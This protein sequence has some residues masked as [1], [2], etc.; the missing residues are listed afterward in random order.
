MK[1]KGKINSKTNKIVQ[2]FTG[3]GLEQ[4]LSGGVGGGELAVKDIIPL[5]RQAAAEGIVMLKNSSNTL[6]LKP[7]DTVSVFGRCAVNYFSVGYGSGG[8]IVKPYLKSLTD[9]L[10]AAGVKVNG[11]LKNIYQKWI[12][13]PDNEIF[14]GFWG[15][16]PMNY[17]EMPLTDDVVRDASEKSNVAV[18]VIGRA[19]G[20]DRENTLTKGSYYLTSAEHKMLK[21]I[22]KYFS[23]TVVIMD[24]GNIV[25][26][27]WSKEYGNKIG[28]ILYAWQGG[29]ESG[30][31]LADVL[32]GNVN[33][34]GKL[35]DTIAVTYNKY[36][37]CE[38]FGNAKFNNYAEDI[39]VGYRYFETFARYDV[40]Y[41]FGYGLSYTTFDIT[42]SCDVNDTKVTVNAQVK[43]TGAYAGKEV[44]QVYLSLPQGTLGNPAKILAAF[45]KTKELS[46]G[47]AEDITLSF[48]LRDLAPY[49]DS[50]KSG[51][52]SAFVLERGLYTIWAGTDVRSCEKIIQFDRDERIV[53]SQLS[54]HLAVKKENVFKRI[55]NNNGKIGYEDV[56]CS[57]TDLKS[58]ILSNLPEETPYTFNEGIKLADVKSGKR[59]M[60]EYIAQLTPKELDDISHGEGEMDSPQGVKGN[61]GCLAGVTKSLRDKGIP[62][63]ITCDGPSGIRMK[64]TAALLPCG[65][66]L[67]S[68]FNTDLVER[69]YELIGDEM[70][71][72]GVN[73]LLAPGMNIH[74]DPLCGR[75]FEYFSE[76]PLLTGEI[77]AAVVKGIQSRGASACPKHFACNN[78]EK[79]RNFNDSRVSERALREIYLRGFQR[80]IEKSNPDVIMTSYNKINGVHSHYN[81]EL[82]T[83]VLRGEWGYR[84]LIITDWWMSKGVS[85]EFPKINNDGYRVR[86]QVD[87]LMPG[88]DGYRASAKVGRTLLDSYQ[89][90][91]GITLGELQR[92]AE[93]VLNLAMKHIK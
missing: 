17:P 18:V 66:A 1:I 44:V 33:P 13:N 93:N 29:M 47:E 34:C 16:W 72:H 46:P 51:T 56:P 86:A 15:H 24:C 89:L 26:M 80:M 81:Y 59:T 25:D 63:V 6:P 76:D 53:V 90:P 52:K 45:A 54:Q 57:T 92:T 20:E 91:E 30:S 71:H 87:V 58:E 55:S 61:A 49:D 3:S 23:R 22:T 11:E 78:Q 67:A 84:G 41:P 75:N 60:K 69:L 35:T 10:E 2:K 32:T 70:V 7:E 40:L 83:S 62:P 77:A 4:E 31:A 85:P 19:A 82:V 42:A 14:E 28:A 48:D 38:N 64:N 36:P 39:Y 12:D 50:G 8:D 9:S 5:A 79:N 27:A 74:R 43:N 65:T 68:T 88:G 73:V 37:T 21:L